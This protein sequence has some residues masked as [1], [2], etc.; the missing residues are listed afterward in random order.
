MAIM[1]RFYHPSVHH[2]RS[3]LVHYTA[4]APCYKRRNMSFKVPSSILTTARRRARKCQY[5]R[6][7]AA[8]YDAAKPTIMQLPNEVLFM[9]FELLDVPSRVCL[10]LTSKVFAQMTRCVDTACNDQPSVVKF[11]Q[12]CTVLPCTYTHHISDRRIMLLQLK[13]WM[14]YGYRLCW[15]C[16]KYTKVGCSEWHCT[17]QVKFNG[18]DGLNVHAIQQAGMDKLY[19]HWKCI[20]SGHA[21]AKW[22][23]ITPGAS[24]G[25]TRLRGSDSPPTDGYVYDAGH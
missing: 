22:S 1:A 13:S 11:H 2:L 7:N 4:K 8:A 10:G 5:R 6:K 20:R 14:P 25:F 17:T 16:L 15:V 18:H 23:R 9:V 12:K 24:G 21:L 19:A 3:R